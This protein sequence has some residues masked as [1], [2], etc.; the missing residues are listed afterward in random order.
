MTMSHD[1]RPTTLLVS[2]LLRFQSI[3]CPRTCRCGLNQRHSCYAAV[4]TWAATGYAK[5]PHA[6]NNKSVNPSDWIPV[7]RRPGGR[8]RS[9]R[10]EGRLLS[11][12]TREAVS[13]CRTYRGHRIS[14]GHLLRVKRTSTRRCGSRPVDENEGTRAG[15]PRAAGGVWAADE[16][17]HRFAWNPPHQHCLL[18]PLRVRA[19]LKH[20][21]PPLISGVS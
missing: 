15:R 2:L 12:R 20:R 14:S 19:L 13:R 9:R 17:I 8:V 21:P 1:V 10:P 11:A 3:S 18:H 5:T 7:R 4:T 6:A 16:P